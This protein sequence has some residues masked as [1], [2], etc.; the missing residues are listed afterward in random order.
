M[1]NRFFNLSGIIAVLGVL[2]ISLL[3]VSAATGN[4]G[5]LP[6]ATAVF[7]SNL[8]QGSANQ[9]AL[10]L[11]MPASA[12]VGETITARLMADK[13]TDLAGFQVKIEYEK[14]N[15]GFLYALVGRDMAVAGGDTFPIGPA[16]L[17]GAVVFGAATCPTPDCEA[18]VHT[19][20]AQSIEGISGTAVELAAFSFIVQK[21]GPQSLNISDVM[22]VNAQGKPFL[23][24]TP[25]L[26]AE[27]VDAPTLTELDVTNSHFINSADASLMMTNWVDLQSDGRCLS[28]YT[29]PHD[30][31]ES[32]CLTVADI[33][34]VLAHWGEFVDIVPNVTLPDV[35]GVT[36]V[37]ATFIVNDD[38]D[39][40]D[41][42]LNDGLCLT[43][44]GN[45]TLR[46]ALEQAN[47]SAGGHTI[48]FDIRDNQGNCP[49]LVTLTPADSLII[50][51]DGITID[52]YTQ[53]NAVENTDPIVG[54]AVIKI[55]IRG[56]GNTPGEYGLHI[57]S[58][59]NTIRGLAVY[60]WHQQIRIDTGDA[61]F[62]Q[63]TF[64][65]TNAANTF[66][67]YYHPAEG[68][69]IRIVYGDHNIL[70]GTS[71]SQRNIISGNEQDGVNIE[72]GSF[73]NTVIGNYVGIAQDGST[74]LRNIADGIDVAEGAYNNII[75]GLLPGE[76]NVISG[77]GRDG[78][79]ISH[80]ASN[81]NNH[82]FGNFI[83]LNAAGTAAVGN[84]HMGVTFEDEVNHNPLYRNIIV[85][86]G[87]NGVRFYAAFENE[88]YD[89]FI[90]V[91][92]TGLNW[93][94][95]VPLPAEVS[96]AD[97][98]VQPNGTDPAVNK[99]ISGVY[100][101]AGSEGN[102]IYRNIIAHHPE[103]GI[104]ANIQ[105][106]YAEIAG[107]ITC[108][109]YHNTFS[110]NSIYANASRGIRLKSGDCFGTTYYP[111]EQI[112]IP[113]ITGAYTTNVSGTT[114][115][116]CTIEIFISDKTVVDSPDNDNNGEGKTF[117]A[118]GAAD[119]SGNFSI[120]VTGLSLDQIITATTTDAVGN[121]SEF[122]RN[123]QVVAPPATDTPTPTNTSTATATATATA[124]NTPTATATATNTPTA[125]ATATA[126]NTPT[127][128]NTLTP[129][130]TA[131]A[132]NT[133]TAT[134][135]PTA[136]PFVPD[137]FTYLPITSKS[138]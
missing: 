21:A 1:R 10:Y 117:I 102:Q 22:L 14:G 83:G 105:E 92:P 131:T 116:N 52:G 130:A 110:R 111:N 54:N 57:L 134:A 96:E 95:P 109:I 5:V 81:Q 33:Q 72:T 101:T 51:Q 91:Y 108:D 136:T 82:F 94:D 106:P 30:V 115:P 60:D 66:K 76:R 123:V 47:F 125:T 74:A 138:P 132:T 93:N 2:I 87:S 12:T 80:G 49:D 114:C 126:T 65:G 50:E 19:A 42:D 7:N 40:S 38:G 127:A 9:P 78:I 121:T 32:G 44:A 28:S 70:G 119:A 18:S 68:D 99:G 62:I 112:A 55:E 97:L 17:D 85:D 6:A 98:A 120:A 84:G 48:H 25:A 129:T 41:D 59:S 73:E 122:A 35:S 20:V 27:A 58:N 29:I 8:V 100:I 31:D 90:G 15:V 53:C 71:P 75:G 137:H 26:Q 39:A 34:M 64:I 107:Y 77:N 103:Y 16:L 67:A 118:S 104:Y 88:V 128:T 135:T 79:E 4:N 63:G 61:N 3:M 89:N 69:G 13:V 133:P 56:D 11:E 45:C 124:T 86:N 37:N 36:A 24:T 113:V 46:A 23:A 43:N